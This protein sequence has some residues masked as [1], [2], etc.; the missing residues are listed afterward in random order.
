M[1]WSARESIRTFAGFARGPGLAL[2]PVPSPSQGKVAMNTRTSLFLLLATAC[3]LVTGCSGTE[4]GERGV[5]TAR[6]ALRRMQ[7]CGDLTQ[8]L[9]DDARVKMNQRIDAEVRA[10]REGYS[11]YYYG[12]GVLAPG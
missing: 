1:S 3:P 8:S 9:R 7:S 6:S 4:S 5:G 12:G 2:G 11:N 10:I